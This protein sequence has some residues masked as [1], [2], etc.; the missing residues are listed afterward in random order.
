VT[1]I[2]LHIDVLANGHIVVPDYRGSRVVEYDADG[3]VVWQ[4]AVNLPAAAQ[5]LPNGHTLVAGR[6]TQEII[7]L[8]RAGKVVWRHRVEGYLYSASRR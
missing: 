7:E 4:A 3:K 8:D 6:G 5:R 2:G 1:L